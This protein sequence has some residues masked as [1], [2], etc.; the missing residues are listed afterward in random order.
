[1]M[2]KK[3]AATTLCNYLIFRELKTKLKPAT[4]SLED[5]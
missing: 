5:S 2:Y 4:P 1:M 3:K